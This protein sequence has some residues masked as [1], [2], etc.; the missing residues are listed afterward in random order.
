M[1]LKREVVLTNTIAIPLLSTFLMFLGLASPWLFSRWMP[2]TPPN[3]YSY[4]ALFISGAVGIGL[5]VYS[6][7]YYRHLMT[8]LLGLESTMQKE[9]RLRAASTDYIVKW[10]AISVTMAPFTDLTLIAL[11]IMILTKSWFVIAGVIT[12]LTI[13]LMLSA[14]DLITCFLIVK[15]TESGDA[16]LF[17]NEGFQVWTVK[18][19]N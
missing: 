14:R 10:Q 3:T 18:V 5:G 9:P 12:F 8:K 19:N 2:I 7:E 17:I 16:I 15:Y 4:I 6:R 11:L 1:H 13:N